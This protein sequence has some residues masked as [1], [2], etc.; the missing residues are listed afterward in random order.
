MVK[1]CLQCKNAFWGGQYCPICKGEVELLDAAVEENQKYLRELNIDVRPK[2][3]ARSAMMLTLFGFIMSLPLGA[4]IFLRGMSS[5]GNV[6]LWACVGLA[7]VVGISWGTWFTAGK[8]FNKQMKDVE[9]V[10]EPQFD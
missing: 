1:F 7:T 2:Y 10:K 4:F 8:I 9:D 6:V 5:A 3:F